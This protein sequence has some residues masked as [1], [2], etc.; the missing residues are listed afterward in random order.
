MYDNTGSARLRISPREAEVYVD[1]YF[2]GTVDDFDGVL[3][4]LHVPAGEHELQFYLEGYRPL[5][6]KVL[7]TRGTTLKIRDT[8]EPLQSG[9]AI[10]PRPKPDPSARPPDRRG[11]RSTAAYGAA[12]RTMYGAITIRVQPADAVILIDGEQWDRPEG[13]TRL[14]VDLPEGQH[15]VEVRK[16]GY[17][18]YT[19]TVRVRRGETVTLNVSL[20]SVQGAE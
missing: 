11:G 7:F 4:R 19:T 3:Q 13:E 14:V 20:T 15:R 2:V 5:R 17:R 16:D 9:E 10:E 12:E 18:T 6:H 1:G 8:M